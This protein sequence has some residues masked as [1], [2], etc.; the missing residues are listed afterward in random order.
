M[1]KKQKKM[2]YESIMK[3]VAK[4]VKKVINESKETTDFEEIQ[5]GEKLPAPLAKLKNMV[6]H[7]NN[8]AFYGFRKRIYRGNPD[9]KINIGVDNADFE[10][11]FTINFEVEDTNTWLVYVKHT[12]EGLETEVASGYLDIDEF[13]E[14]VID[15]I[16]EAANSPEDYEE[17]CYS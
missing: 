5:S 3:Q 13:T 1:N 12:V 15:V 11:F 2:L 4:T 9:Y 16:E 6:N 7:N 17:Y 14:Q 8:L 10:F